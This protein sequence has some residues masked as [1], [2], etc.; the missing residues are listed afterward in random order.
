M[1]IGILSDTHDRTEAMSKAVQLLQS[2]GAA[3][4]LHC[5]DVGSPL[6]LDHLAG[7]KAAFVWG[8]CDFDRL[9]LQ[10]YAKSIGIECFG[11]FGELE[12][13]GKK[14]ALTH[15]DDPTLKR[16]ILSEQ[17]HD[18][19]FQGHTHLPQDIRIGKIHLIN[20]GA[21]H[22][23]NPKTCALLN[24]DADTVEFLKID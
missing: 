17:R 2:K 8:N 7:L 10:R 22:R 11:N 13:A 19:F 3:F 5:G 23:A 1:L 15:G 6:V 21:L 20:P 4:F 14:L 12:L 9:G 18:Y 16:R 24:T